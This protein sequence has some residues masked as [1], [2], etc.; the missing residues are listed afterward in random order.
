MED[1]I[2]FGDL[3]NSNDLIKALNSDNFAKLTEKNQT[4]L[5]NQ[6][7][8]TIEKEA[9]LMG[10]FFG[11]KKENASIH[12]AFTICV[13]LAIIGI[14]CMALGKNYWNVI[15]PGIMTAV[16]YIFGKGDK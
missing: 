15:I 3:T 14:I 5:L 9:G 7:N 10:K 1:N 6:L 13:L 16:G 8:Y 12:I 11:T 4:L 2:K